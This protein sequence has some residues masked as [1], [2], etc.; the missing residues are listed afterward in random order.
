MLTLYMPARAEC[1]AEP[2]PQPIDQRKLL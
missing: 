2:H 1:E